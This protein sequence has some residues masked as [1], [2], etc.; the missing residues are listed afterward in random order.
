[1]S[2]FSSFSLTPGD[3]TIVCAWNYDIAVIDPSNLSQLALYVT[4]TDILDETVK[5]TSVKVDAYTPSYG[6]A[7]TLNFEITGLINGHNYM[8][9]LEVITITNAIYNSDPEYE[10]P[11]GIPS[12]PGFVLSQTLPDSFTVN[13][14]DLSGD[15]VPP[16][17]N[18]GFD[19]YSIITGAYVVYSDAHKIKTKFFANDASNS[20]YYRDLV[21][22]VSNHNLHEVNVKTINSI[23]MSNLSVAQHIYVDVYPTVPRNAKCIESITKGSAA[24]IKLNW[25]SPTFLGRPA[26]DNYEIYRKGP[27]DVS[28]NWLQDIEPSNNLVAYDTDVVE[29]SVYSYKVR[30]SNTND[31]SFDL[32]PNDPSFNYSDF[33]LFDPS[34]ITAVVYP[35]IIQ[36]TKTPGVSKFTVDISANY[37]GFSS[38]YITYDIS[39][40]GRD[41]NGSANSTIDISGDNGTKYY[42]QA[43][44]VATSM[45]DGTITYESDWSAVQWSMPFGP[46]QEPSGL[47]ASPLDDSNE[48]LDGAIQLTWTDPAAESYDATFNIEVYQKLTSSVDASYVSI[49]TVGSGVQEYLVENLTNGTNYSFKIVKTIIS[50]ETG[51]TIY[52]S[53]ITVAAD[54]PFT[55][56]NA[57]TELSYV[58][59]TLNYSFTTPSNN[60]GLVLAGYKY[61]LENLT[62]ETQVSNSTISTIA[63]TINSGTIPGNHYQLTISSYVTY[64]GQDYES[65]TVNDDAYT[66]PNA[67]AAP[68][69]TNLSGS[70]PTT[71]SIAV[72]W[73]LP[74]NHDSGATYNLYRDS[75]LISTAQAGTTY[76]DTVT[77]GTVNSY[78]VK[79]IIG[80]LESSAS[81]ASSQIVPFTY[82]NTITGLVDKVIDSN[83]VDISFNAA[84]VG[85]SGLQSSQL[86]YKIDWDRVDSSNISYNDSSGVIMDTQSLSH[87]IT[88]LIVGSK[89]LLRVYT[90]VKPGYYNSNDIFYETVGVNMYITSYDLANILPPSDFVAYP[91]NGSFLIDWSNSANP[92]DVSGATFDRY[93]IRYV[94]EADTV[95][96]TFDQN[97][98]LF[99]QNN[100]VN[101]TTYTVYLVA[102][103]KDILGR[104]ILSSD[105]S[106]NVTPTGD[107]PS[108]PSSL[109][110]EN[111][112]S[113]KVNVSWPS[114]SNI[115]HYSIYLNDEIY[116]HH[117]DA[118]TSD[119]SF[120]NNK[121]SIIVDLPA[122]ISSNTIG[123]IS[124]NL[125][126]GVY[127]VS[128]FTKGIAVN[129]VRPSAVRSSYYEAANAT[130][131]D[132]SWNIPSSV[133]NADSSGNGAIQYLVRIYDS[134][135][136]VNESIMTDG[137]FGIINNINYTFSNLNDSTNYTVKIYALYKVANSDTYAESPAVTI[138][139][140]FA[141]RQP[142]TPTLTASPANVSGDGLSVKLDLGYDSDVSGA[143]VTLEMSM[144]IY[145]STNVNLVSDG[146]TDIVNIGTN[147]LGRGYSGY[148]ASSYGSQT[149]YHTG[150]N[151]PAFLNGMNIIYKLVVTYTNWTPNYSPKR[152]ITL[153]SPVIPYG[154]PLF[155]NSIT[156]TNNNI[157][158]FEFSK[159]GSDM[160]SII[161]IG[162]DASNASIPVEIL[163]GTKLSNLLVGQ[164]TNGMSARDYADK[165]LASLSIN[166]GTDIKLNEVLI[167]M[168]NSGD[169]VTKAFPSN[170]GTFGNL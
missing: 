152:E 4:D 42:F 104:D 81:S 126:S 129:S 112:D 94:D 110:I 111:Y 51:S 138:T 154:K 145:N 67:P 66:T 119:L 161:L 48:P 36:V 32:I 101:D 150:G 85:S 12:K 151:E 139:N 122:D 146:T 100:V 108:Q 80:T 107:I 93:R 25:D 147:G 58:N 105:S 135:G 159:N 149:L 131:V 127:I 19:N 134:N 24:S 62:T 61:V 64:N 165:Q 103:Y 16:L 21:V 120:E 49:Y 40:N 163:S 68:S 140:V 73:S 22:D 27:N 133:G 18:S 157:V 52:S 164:Y 29:G 56:P 50:E 137:V 72:S 168:A 7:P 15:V 26:V 55:Y 148:S 98:T 8:I 77:N 117:F 141:R 125:V 160:N 124:E 17:P 82:A 45:V 57:V 128:P 9:S 35:T 91:S 169:T 116:A 13:L 109:F 88:G 30:A 47:S 99:Y 86:Y 20:L 167:V 102:I 106:G 10:T 166:M 54:K 153:A 43:R 87:S 95:E 158:N 130:T 170:S 123:V 23:G 113:N 33:I 121:W 46:L 69:V 37:G 143:A 156:F 59:S 144:F 44:V 28:F 2:G 70:T 89:Y 14:M 39:C 118:S 65:S 1:M 142:A 78:T 97:N 3:A 60:G 83:S 115:T 5:T 63:G 76:N 6:T 114:A 92:M 31:A 41:V 38:D 75:T 71:G 84:A 74:A 155:R 136:F 96:N 79:V 90:G 53:G 34:N 162:I 132:L 11:K